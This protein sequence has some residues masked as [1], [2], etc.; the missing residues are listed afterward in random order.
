MKKLLLFLLVFGLL[1]FCRLHAQCNY[2][3]PPSIK[4]ID[5]ASREFTFSGTTMNGKKTTF[6]AVQKGA[7]VNISTFVESRKK[8]DYCPACIVQVYWGI[9]GHVSTC[10][11]SFYGYQFKRKKTTQKFKA[12]DKDGIYYITMGGTLDYSCKNNINRPRCEAEYAIAVLKVGNPDPQQKVTLTKAKAGNGSM[13][14]TTLVKPGCFGV[15]DKTEWFLNGNKLAFDN[16]KEIPLTGYG[17]YEVRWFN[18]NTS[19]SRTYNYSADGNDVSN[20][21]DPPASVGVIKTSEP[22]NSANTGNTGGVAQGTIKLTGSSGTKDS[23]SE[24]NN[25]NP[26]LGVILQ[27]NPVKND[28]PDEPEETDIEKLIANNDK[29]IL[30][31]LVFDLGQSY[32]R[33]EAKLEL[34]KLSGYMQT[35]PTMKILLEGHTDRIGNARKN[36][37]LSEERVESAKSYLVAQGIDSRNIRTKGWGHEKPLVI[38]DNVEE[39]KVNRRVEITILSR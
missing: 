38:T 3:T 7:S 34:D 10:G 30:E 15:L 28:E 25:Q 9:R 4:K 24:Q 13:L 22:K 29:F 20:S 37:I 35:H 26:A 11:K 18:C 39:G 19:I 1:G 6:L 17:L 21:V 8:G 31:H 14:K 27:G 5:Y 12:P 23:K 16:R 36:R 33:P 2:I 32:L